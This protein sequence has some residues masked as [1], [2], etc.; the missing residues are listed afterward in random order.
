[1]K[2]CP[3]PGCTERVQAGRCPK[4]QAKR[5][6]QR[7]LAE[8]RKLYHSARWLALRRR[9][10]QEQ[11]TC[12][13]CF[14]R[15]ARVVA[16]TDVDHIAPHRGDLALFWDRENLQAMCKACHSRKTQAGM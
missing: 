1:M 16:S 15:D 10:L 14:A 3:E 12:P 7:P 2:L 13:W 5:E 8:V 9:V 4:C 11:P 6:R